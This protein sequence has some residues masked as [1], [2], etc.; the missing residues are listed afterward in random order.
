MPDRDTD[1]V[2]CDALSELPINA[3]DLICTQTNNV[4]TK[5]YQSGNLNQTIL[6]KRVDSD[7]EEN[8]VITISVRNSRSLGNISQ[9]HTISYD[10]SSNSIT[11]SSPSG[12]SGN[13]SSQ[14]QRST[15]GSRWNDIRGVVGTNYTSVKVVA[16]PLYKHAETYVACELQENDI[17]P[18]TVRD[19]QTFGVI[20][21]D[22]VVFKN[23]RP[24]VLNTSTSL[25]GGNGS[26]FKQWRFKR[27]DDNRAS[28]R[29]EINKIHLLALLTPDSYFKRR[30]EICNRAYRNVIPISDNER[31][32]ACAIF[33]REIDCCKKLS[34][35]MQ[36][37]NVADGAGNNSDVCQR[38]IGWDEGLTIY[39]K[40]QP[41]YKPGLKFPKMYYRLLRCSREE[42]SFTSPKFINTLCPVFVPDSIR[43]KVAYCNS[44]MISLSVSN[45]YTY[46]WLCDDKNKIAWQSVWQGIVT[47]SASYHY[48]IENCNSFWT[49]SREAF[50]NV[51]FVVDKIEVGA[52]N[53]GV[54]IDENR[55]FFYLKKESN[56]SDKNIDYFMTNVHDQK[57]TKYRPKL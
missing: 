3:Q 41:E 21:N 39:G 19:E 46:C 47:Q 11:A 43:L 22:R 56:H 55:I 45:P 38:I 31:S 4:S 18:V 40:G 37:I 15:S 49:K 7:Y 33:S 53:P 30:L 1:I 24:N 34:A 28:V 57:L 26:L 32:T 10:S 14:L 2:I 6:F 27:D 42:T 25:S 8:N 54:V 29:D 48:H 12:G 35:Q 36:F 44:D 13:H 9:S 5:Y 17:I 50:F 16:S 51:D 20:K 52:V 23:N